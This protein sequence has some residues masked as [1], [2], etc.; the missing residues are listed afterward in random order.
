MIRN[1]IFDL[2]GVIVTLSQDEAIRRFAE[3]G[4]P[5]AARR[6]DPYTQSGIF[7]DVECGRITAEDFRRELSKMTGREQ[8]FD[9]CKWAWLGYFADLPRRNLD[10]LRSL[11]QEGYR[12]L[13]LSNTN[14]FTM[15]W[16][17]SSEFDG[18]GHSLR[19]YFDACYLSY[20][21]KILKP[22]EEFFRHVLRAE[23]IDPAETLFV[24]DGPRNVAAASQLGIN[25]LCPANGSDWTQDLRRLLSRAV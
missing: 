6:L 2:G 13:L 9:T 11:R 20:E 4:V 1:I 5:D 14:P 18:R 7:G 10:L 25:T 8:T 22:A 16:G 21:L 19:D 3:L 12:L 17:M 24:D 23:R 15:S